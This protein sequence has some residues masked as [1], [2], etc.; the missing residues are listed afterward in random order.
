MNNKIPEL[1][2]P[3]GNPEKL[4]VA[5]HYGA[6]AVYLGGREYSLRANAGNFA[7]PELVEAVAFAHA[8]QV[9]VYVTVNIF[10]HQ[11]DLA[12]LPAYLRQ[13]RA[14]EV[15]G[16]IV[17]DPGVFRLA[18]AVVPELPI[19]LSTQANVTNAEAAAFWHEQGA[20]RLNLARE[21]G[22]AE[23]AAIRRATAAELEIFVHGA[24]CISYSGRCL[25]SLY[26]TGRD[27]N[28]GD[29]AH[30]CRYRYRLEEEKRPGQFFPVG[31]DERGT[32]IFN[33]KDLCL[34]ARL[35]DL[36]RAGADALKIEGRMKSVFYLGG[37]VRLY[38][39]ALDYWREQGL[40]ASLPPEFFAEL[41]R[42]G[43]RGQSLNFLDGPPG[44]DDMLYQGATVAAAQTPA[45]I[46]RDGGEQPLVEARNLLRVG[47]Q[48]EY[49]APG[50]R[51]LPLQIRAIH[52]QDGC[53]V[54]RANPNALVRLTLE[55]AVNCETHGLLR[56]KT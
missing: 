25:L 48:L 24:L 32:Y 34:L 17:A 28:Q 18:R 30:P 2:A 37:V 9:K 46:V 5:V 50:L 1:L 20:R 39:A 56:R 14:L 31:E 53:P 13:L 47:D 49:L 45:A 43:S 22:L 52:D 29:C 6:D 7:A 11:P 33:A 10:A 44:R 4:R 54:E 41:A 36:I 15:D 51:N 27:A 26:L 42:L 40:A 35:P 38:R 3:A 23:I 55:P 21:L 16:L 19:H 8:R 12:G